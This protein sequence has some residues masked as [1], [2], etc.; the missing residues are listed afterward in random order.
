MYGAETYENE[1]MYGGG[2]EFMIGLLCGAAVGAAVGLLLAPKSGAELRSQ[3]ADSAEKFRRK[4]GE[5]Y[6]QASNKM[7]D[8]VDKGRDAVRRGK[9][10]MD[11]V[12]STAASAASN[13][14]GQSY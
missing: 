12:R 4:A 9:E 2:N 1:N 5:T 13:A 3:L 7:G 14:T 8:M 11:E 6:D 10:K